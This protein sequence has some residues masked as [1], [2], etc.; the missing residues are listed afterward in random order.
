M[1]IILCSWVVRVEKKKKI[2]KITTYR[3]I[4]FPD[5]YSKHTCFLFWP[6]VKSCP[7]NLWTVKPT[8]MKD[9][10]FTEVQTAN[11]PPP[12]PPSTLTPASWWWVEFGEGGG[13]LH[14]WNKVCSGVG[15]TSD[16]SPPS[17]IIQTMGSTSPRFQTQAR[18]SFCNVPKFSDG[19]MAKQCRPRS[20]CSWSG[21]THFAILSASFGLITLW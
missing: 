19:Y 4:F 10:C 13:G 2:N 17:H 14:M 5:M 21:S 9:K 1:A 11:S 7:L 6:R 16:I 20:D 3:P 18:N 12:N 15:E 8:N